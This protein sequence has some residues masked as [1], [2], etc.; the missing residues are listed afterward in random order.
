VT[1]FRD[2]YL[3]VGEPLGMVNQDVSLTAD[4][5]VLILNPQTALIRIT[6]DNTTATN[7]TFTFPNG[8]RMGQQLL[9]TVVS[10]GA[11]TCQLLDAGNVALSAAWTPQL[12]DTLSLVWTGSSW[13]EVA[14]SDN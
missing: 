4:D 2:G 8:Y 3:V 11:T 9:L 13:V 7:R 6:S 12:N 14:R 10:A 1:N 5:Q